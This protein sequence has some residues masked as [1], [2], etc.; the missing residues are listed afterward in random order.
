MDGGMHRSSFLSSLAGLG[1]CGFMEAWADGSEKWEAEVLEV[2]GRLAQRAP[3]AGGV[4]FAG[5]SS[6]RLWDLQAAFPGL[7]PL[8]AG[9]GGSSI[10]EC[11]RF[12]PRLIH[13]W[14]PGTVVFY[15]GDNDIAAGLSAEEV[16]DD[17]RAFAISLHGVLP[18]CRLLFLS[19]KPSDLRWQ[20]WPRARE[21]NERIRNFCEAVG[22]PRLRYVDV[23]SPLLGVDG[24]PRAE[25]YDADRLHLNAAGYA[26]WQ[27]V[28]GPLLVRP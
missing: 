25:F 14:R 16:A 8:N 15:A 18:E 12:A 28:L 3:A 21:A 1:I 17:F 26:E 5:S 20:L 2:E 13:V 10:A 7:A 9:F 22:E 6:I 19:I 23:A 11:A 24:R 27:A 4:L